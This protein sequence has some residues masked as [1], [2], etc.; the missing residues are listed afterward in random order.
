MVFSPTPLNFVLTDLSSSV[1]LSQ[2]ANLTSEVLSISGDAVAVLFVKTSDI[3]K[4]FQFE[5]DAININDLSA[6]DMKFYVDMSAW[7]TSQALNPLNPAN[8]MMDVPVYSSGPISSISKISGAPYDHNK[9]LVKHDFIR[10]IAQ[11]MFN[12]YQAVD[13]FNNQL[14]VIQNIEMV[15][16][17]SGVGHSWH[18]ISAALYN[19]D[20][21]HGR[22][23][24][25]L[26]DAN[27]LKY[28]TTATTTPDNLS[29]EL[30]LQIVGNQP[31]RLTANAD[32]SSRV[33]G[34]AD[35]QNMIFYDGDTINFNLTLQAASGQESV[36]GLTN[37]S[38]VP[39]RTYVIKLVMIS[40]SDVS[41]VNTQTD[42]IGNTIS[43][44]SVGKLPAD[45]S[46]AA[47][48]SYA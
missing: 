5:T 25:L 35:R 42:S 26:V 13:L 22:N 41:Y 30:F 12:T 34:S 14:E 11:K 16:D 48:L 6:Q 23:S 7:P 45:V 1:T 39:S 9:A 40:D 47:T 21:D 31:N 38:P 37:I 17:G 20:K 33:L 43:I 19:V 46:T 15:C 27:G 18:D 32:G 10:H 4:V 36:S 29:R 2:T 24:G 28:M 44:D 3:K 8:A